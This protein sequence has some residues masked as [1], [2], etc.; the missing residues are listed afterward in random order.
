MLMGKEIEN[1][2]Q[3]C[4]EVP[5]LNIS[6]TITRIGYRYT[7]EKR[8]SGV[9]ITVLPISHNVFLE[10]PFTIENFSGKIYE[11]AKVSDMFGCIN[12]IDNIASQTPML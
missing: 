2:E 10:F 7:V 9:F 8:V 6:N 12:D 1:Y 11:L 4:E 5:E 3:L